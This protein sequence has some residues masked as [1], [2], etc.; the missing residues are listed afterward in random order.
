ML[1]LHNLKHPRLVLCTH[2]LIVIPFY[3][4][5]VLSIIMNRAFSFRLRGIYSVACQFRD[6]HYVASRLDRCKTLI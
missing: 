2:S 6:L 5:F 3:Y 4:H 1:C